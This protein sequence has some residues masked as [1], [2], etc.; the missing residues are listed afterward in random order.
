MLRAICVAGAGLLLIAGATS[1]CAGG[2]ADA[3]DGEPLFSTGD[4]TVLAGLGPETPGWGWSEAPSRTRR[5]DRDALGRNDANAVQA[6]LT[7]SLE[8]AEFVS[9]YGATW[10]GERGQ[11]SSGATLSDTVEG[12][13]EIRKAAETFTRRY[14]QEIERK[15][16]E[17][18]PVSGLGEE[19]WGVRQIQRGS[20]ATYSMTLGWRRSNLN[21]EAHMVCGGACPPDLEQALRAW[22]DA[23]DRE[24]VRVAA[25][26]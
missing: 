22:A 23:I 14:Q 6:E 10:E 11:A 20:G 25:R 4:L 26:S 5:L 2:G 3:V 12:A 16:V 7:E 19:A 13:R 18:L 9:H 15:D 21:L 17:E 24:A 1:S 8:N